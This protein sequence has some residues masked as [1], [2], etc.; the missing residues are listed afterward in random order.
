LQEIAYAP[1]PTPDVSPHRSELAFRALH[2]S[3]ENALEHVP[4]PSESGLQIPLF[5]RI[6]YG[7]PLH[8]SPENAL[9]FA[10]TS[11]TLPR[12][13][14]RSRRRSGK[15][16]EN[17]SRFMTP[18]PRSR[19][20]LLQALVLTGGAL[21]AL[22]APAA[23][24][25]AQS[26]TKVRV[27]ETAS[28]S[29]LGLYVAMQK[30]MFRKHGL[31][32][33]RVAVPGGAKVLS[34]MLSGDI[35]IGYLAAATALQAQFQAR[36]VKIIGVTHVMEIY[37]LLVRNDLK[38]IVSKP[39]DFKDRTIGISSIG[40]G[41]WAYANLLA[42]AGGLDAARDIKIVPLGNMMAIISALKTNRVDAVTLWEPG[43]TMALA[44]GM[45]H[46]VIDLQSPINDSKPGDSAQSMV[47][48]IAAKDDLIAGQPDMLRR[49]FAA[50]NEAYAW[51]HAAPIDELAQT[52][53]P[54]VGESNMAILR[55]SL[56]RTLPGVPKI[57]LVDEKVYTA[58]MSQMVESG[59]FKEAQPFARAVD[60]AFGDAR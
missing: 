37:S 28:F 25:T 2:T 59:L 29:H 5:Y 57:A 33:E 13:L 30:D 11:P 23:T 52:V 46:A 48:V 49:F 26:L 4:I 53:A 45:G 27:G 1:R 44:E 55:Q 36:P 8:T 47:E 9:M 58:T 7:E 22:L 17:R 14:M 34:A 40:S 56:K 35:D 15:Q 38:G 10:V 20:A 12:V 24:A 43:I 50:E 32:I 18:R 31:E 42:R 21:L 54:I 39:A 51:I 60:N 6:F 16:S 41:S 3:P 19:R